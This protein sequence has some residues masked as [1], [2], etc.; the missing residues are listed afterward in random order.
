[1]DLSVVDTLVGVF[2]PFLFPVFL[3]AAGVVGYVVLY[4]LNGLRVS[5]DRPAW[6][7]WRTDGAETGEETADVDRQ[8]G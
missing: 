7:E 1:M 2:G 4:L 5:E 3:F 6:R 8:E